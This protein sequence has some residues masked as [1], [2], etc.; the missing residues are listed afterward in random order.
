MIQI[1][2]LF[3][4]YPSKIVYENACLTINKGEKIGLIGRNGSGKSTLLEVITN[5][6]FY[7]GEINYKSN[8][9]IGYY[10]QDLAIGTN[11]TVNDILYKPFEELLRIEEKMESLASDFQTNQEEYYKLFEEFENKG[12]YFITTNINQMISIFKLSDILNQNVETLSGGQKARVALAKV[13]LEKPDILLLDEP[14]NHLD[15]EGIE[16][17]EKFINSYDNTLIVISHD[18]YFL[19]NVCNTIVEVINFGLHKYKG[20]YTAYINQSSHNSLS[21]ENQFDKQ[22]VEI[23]KLKNQIKQYRIWG[24]SRS[25]EKMFKKAKELE[26]RLGKIELIN[27][28][29]VK[30]KDMRLCFKQ[31][32]RSGYNVIWAENLSIGYD[33]VLIDNIN[34]DIYQF[35]RVAFIGP[36]GVGKSTL[37]K[38]I[39]NK[40]SSLSGECR[41]GSGVQIG[42]FDQ[43]FENLDNTNSVF[44]EIHSANPNMTNFE[45]RSHL[46]KF[47]FRNE[48]LDKTI[49]TLSGG[50]CV[51]VCLAKL[52]LQ[53]TNV[54]VLDEPTNHL[55]LESKQIVE[56]ALLNYEGTIIFSSHDRYFINKLANKIFD[57]SNNSFK[58]VETSYFDY[59]NSNSNI[60]T[61]EDLTVEHID[62]KNSKLNRSH[63]QKQKRI[64]SEIEMLYEKLETLEKQKFDKDFYLYKDKM[65]KLEIEIEN[66]N[67]KI[68]DLV[69]CLK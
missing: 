43:I 10:T 66:V 29:Y 53:E 36:N 65:Y 59:V 50:E 44:E 14:L 20:N 1:N 67:N 2:K 15:I 51:R 39:A 34:F 25:S 9:K 63:L 58:L 38:I 56:N 32:K 17:L 48:E 62:Y 18:R 60:N 16:W 6:V 47:L 54:L 24:E 57:F 3:K 61:Q 4:T 30:D 33:D 7:D 37:L 11:V 13:L 35:D 22:Q 23:S 52:S 68:L 46:A 64:E 21:L 12:G 26:K 27:N 41:Y 42:Y 28:P 55:D 45:I 31:S 5:K 19:D 40:L 69:D 49:S 8:L